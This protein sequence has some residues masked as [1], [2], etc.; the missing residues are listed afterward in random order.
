MR[1]VACTIF[2]MGAMLLLTGCGADISYAPWGDLT[3]YF[4]LGEIKSSRGGCTFNSYEIS[5]GKIPFVSKRIDDYQYNAT[6]LGTDVWV[7]RSPKVA[8]YTGVCKVKTGDRLTVLRSAG[9]IDGRYWSY[10]HIDSGY[11]SGCQGYICTDYIIEQAKY[12]VINEY[13][14][15]ANSNINLQTDSKYIHAIADVL[16]QLNV[17]YNHPRLFVSMIDST[18]AG[19]HI[20][21]TFQIRDYGI[22]GNDTM[23]AF[24]RFSPSRNDFV[25]L[26][27]VPGKSVDSIIRLADGSYDINYYM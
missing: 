1:R 15:S 27:V 22:T 10:V 13:V 4:D 2:S 5:D 18:Y 12:E 16:L 3:A 8:S 24:V 17:N 6:V 20:I 19:E 14:L 9:Y 11:N 25:V 23:L 26:G 21:V 7:R